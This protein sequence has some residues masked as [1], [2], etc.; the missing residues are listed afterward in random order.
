M[1]ID[2]DDRHDLL[3]VIY[4]LAC[5]VS[6]TLLASP[7]RY[8]I[9][10]FWDMRCKLKQLDPKLKYYIPAEKYFLKAVQILHNNHV[11]SLVSMRGR[12]RDPMVIVLDG[13]DVPIQTSLLNINTLI[14]LLPTCTDDKDY[15][16]IYRFINAVLIKRTGLS[17]NDWNIG[18][19]DI[20]FKRALYLLRHSL[21]ALYETLGTSDDYNEEA[22][23]DELFN[24]ICE[25]YRL[26]EA[27]EKIECAEITARD[28]N[29]VNLV[30]TVDLYRSPW[31]G[32]FDAVN[33]VQNE[34][35]EFGLLPKF[36]RMIKYY[37]DE[38]T[39]ARDEYAFTDIDDLDIEAVKLMLKA[40][41]IH[42]YI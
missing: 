25:L 4:S 30:T 15:Q 20:M 17:F 40:L 36:V 31:A 11:P 16:I 34:L 2:R 18:S 35:G 5:S 29:F 23:S 10:P 19:D 7:K 24:I 38:L 6:H 39:Y 27:N 28:L 41:D 9:E 32:T 13:I 33:I 37:G 12:N 26:V 22:H 42:Q 3:Q 1:G 21:I 8:H 14:N